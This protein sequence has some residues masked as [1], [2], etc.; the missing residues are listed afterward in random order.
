MTC[1]SAGSIGAGAGSATGSGIG[2]GDAI[3]RAVSA[4]K[5]IQTVITRREMEVDWVLYIFV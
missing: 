2:A 1:A 5:S 3:A 4:N